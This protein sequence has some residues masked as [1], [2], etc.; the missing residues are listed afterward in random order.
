MKSQS[1]HLA[2]RPQL[3]NRG[4]MGGDSWKASDQKNERQA[5]QILKRAANLGLLLA[6]RHLLVGPVRSAWKASMEQ[7]HRI[8]TALMR[9][10]IMAWLA[11]ISLSWV[12]MLL[13]I[14]ENLMLLFYHAFKNSCIF[15]NRVTAYLSEGVWTNT[16]KMLRCVTHTWNLSYSDWWLSN[17]NKGF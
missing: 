2:N 16:L 10:Q 9:E 3:D 13:E 17:Q 5:L 8:K 6:Y 11:V 4:A 14:E 12:M 15:I 7:I 1:L